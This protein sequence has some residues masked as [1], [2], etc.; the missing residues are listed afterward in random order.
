MKRMSQEAGHGL[1]PSAL[2]ALAH[3]VR[4]HLEHIYDKIDVSTRVAATLFA[5]EHG[6][7]HAVSLGVSI[8]PVDRSRSW[9]SQRNTGG[10]SAPG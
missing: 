2:A 7:L 8:Q 5:I 1:C 6:L 10:S 9:R 4:H 3:T